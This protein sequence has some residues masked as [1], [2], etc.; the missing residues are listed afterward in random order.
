MSGV[1]AVEM[2]PEAGDE[3]RAVTEL[4]TSALDH[5]VSV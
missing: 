3:G 1:Y 5:C 2:L 4:T